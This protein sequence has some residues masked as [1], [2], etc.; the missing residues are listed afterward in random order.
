MFIE[1]LTKTTCALE[2]PSQGEKKAI[3][4]SFSEGHKEGLPQEIQSGFRRGACIEMEARSPLSQLPPR[5]LAARPAWVRRTVPR[6]PHV[7]RR[8]WSSIFQAPSSLSPPEGLGNS[9]NCCL[10]RWD[11]FV[12][13]Y[14]LKW[15]RE[16]NSLLEEGNTARFHR[17]RFQQGIWFYGAAVKYLIGFQFI[18][19][20]QNMLSPFKLRGHYH[21]YL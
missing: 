7:N 12:S 10:W 2:L 15:K 18:K 14:E 1:S 5:A 9:A 13:G 4:V 3:I 20:F 19:H 8:S 6:S 16:L 21:V 11:W 17:M